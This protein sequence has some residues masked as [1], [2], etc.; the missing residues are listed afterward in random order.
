MTL[1]ILKGILIAPP[2]KVYQLAPIKAMTTASATSITGQRR[3]RGS[4]EVKCDQK[5]EF[6]HVKKGDESDPNNTTTGLDQQ[7]QR[8]G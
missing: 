6:Q 4:Q 1:V 8:T 5:G 7:H 3:S 2:P